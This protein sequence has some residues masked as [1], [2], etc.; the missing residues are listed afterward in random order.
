MSPSPP[1][2]VLKACG[3]VLGIIPLEYEVRPITAEALDRVNAKCWEGRDAQLRILERQEI[4][5]FGAWDGG[6]CVAQLHGYRV[7]LPEFDTSPFPGYARNRLEDW[8]LGW[9]L[10]AARAKG[11]S[12]DGPVW[13]LACFHV[14]L[15]PGAG[16][17]DSRYFRKGIGTALMNASVRWAGERGYAAVLAHGGS[18]VLSEYNIWMGS[19][20]WKVYG[21]A[22]FASV[23]VE[24]GAAR[25]P[26]WRDK[27]YPEF[28]RQIDEALAQGFAPDDLCAR[29]M[30]REL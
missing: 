1:Y 16:D 10:L 18:N 4:L 30:I 23:A 15:L 27:A 11:I 28:R 25:L 8:P 21:A 7:N 29:C 17:P 20:P 2:N 3:R 9:P 14:G 24:E 13:G 22:G 6:E 12:Y 5:G 19:L 26:W